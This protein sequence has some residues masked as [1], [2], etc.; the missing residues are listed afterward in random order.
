[1]AF[2]QFCKDLSRI[3]ISEDMM[4]QKE[5]EILEIL[6]PHCMLVSQIDS[7]K[8][9]DRGELPNADV[10]SFAYVQLLTYLQS[11][12][13]KSTLHLDSDLGQTALHQFRQLLH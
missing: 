5:G 2:K 3:G 7:S 9:L 6:R 13:A 4:H 8:T 12:A 1:M 11:A 10:F